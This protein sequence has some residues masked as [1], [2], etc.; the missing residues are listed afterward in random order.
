MHLPRDR[1]VAG[2][3]MAATMASGD[4]AFESILR[5]P[6]ASADFV[7]EAMTQRT[8]LGLLSD[9]GLSR[10]IASVEQSKSPDLSAL[11]H[12]LRDEVDARDDH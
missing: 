8:S 7:R 5:D 1:T 3:E 2:G 10:L 6:E 11:L 4:D 12:Y 9:R